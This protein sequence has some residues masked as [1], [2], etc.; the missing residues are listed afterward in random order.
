MAADDGVAAGAKKQAARAAE[1]V[2]TTARKAR[3]TVKKAAGRT[4]GTAR[5]VRAAKAGRVD[6]A[7]EIV[8]EA[9]IDEGIASKAVEKVEDQH[10]QVEV[11]KRALSVNGLTKA[12][13]ERWDNGWALAH[14]LEQR[15]N[16]VLV[17]EKRQ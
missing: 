4:T 3:K 7:R 9:G 16:T 1:S 15:G 5:A 11:N 12:L 17:F 2:T 13:N 10:Y 14:N 6:E 8:D